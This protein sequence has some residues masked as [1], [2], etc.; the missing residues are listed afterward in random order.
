MLSLCAA[1]IASA[2]ARS[3]EGARLDSMPWCAAV[4]GGYS[5]LCRGEP[6][7]RSM[8]AEILSSTPATALGLLAK[9]HAVRV[10]RRDPESEPV[11]YA[12]LADDIIRLFDPAAACPEIANAGESDLRTGAPRLRHASADA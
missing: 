1:F 10:Y 4:D 9:A 12:A 11:S 7:H 5:E 8:L 6:A 2:Q 3:I